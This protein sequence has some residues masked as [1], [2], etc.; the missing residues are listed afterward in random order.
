VL[1]A[2]PVAVFALL[3]WEIRA[4]RVPSWDRFLLRHLRPLGTHEPTHELLRLAFLTAGDVVVPIALAAFVAW[5]LRRG[6]GRDA[7]FLVAAVG[8]AVV[9]TIV[10]KRIV[11]RP[12]IEAHQLE[13][14]FP[15]GH[16]TTALAIALSLALLLPRRKT[17][18]A[19]AVYV[20]LV[21]V[22]AVA[23]RYHYPSDVA[24]GWCVALVCVG[25]IRSITRSFG[26]PKPTLR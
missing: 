15:S 7:V 14:S 19:G 16:S 5:L 1:L 26:S 25:G 20:A 18:L 24:A 10:L 9:A 22:A 2:L 3:W 6:R 23:L 11:A 4:A 12:S 13:S 21:A 17:V 8:T